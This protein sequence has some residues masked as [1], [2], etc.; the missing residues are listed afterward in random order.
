[1]FVS[2]EEAKKIIDET[3]GLIW[4]DDFNNITFVHSRPKIITKME[5][6]SLINRAENIDF[7]DEEIFGLLSLSCKPIVHNIKFAMINKLTE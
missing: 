4:L 6:N 5:S 2:K 7:Q 1:M 3:T